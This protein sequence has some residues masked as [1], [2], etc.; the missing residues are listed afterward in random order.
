VASR[1]VARPMPLPAPVLTVVVSR[2]C[3]M[4]LLKAGQMYQFFVLLH[5]PVRP[6]P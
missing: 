6:D 3:V 4:I 1:A 5:R 2:S